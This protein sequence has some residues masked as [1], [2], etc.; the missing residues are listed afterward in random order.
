MSLISVTNM[1]VGDKLIS[2]E[3]HLYIIGTGTKTSFPSSRTIN[4]IPIQA[5]P[6]MNI[7]AF[8]SQFLR[9]SFIDLIIGGVSLEL[10]ALKSARSYKDCWQAQK[11][12]FE[13]KVNSRLL[14]ENEA[15]RTSWFFS[16]TWSHFTQHQ[17]SYKILQKQ[18][19]RLSDP[20]FG[21]PSVRGSSAK[22]PWI[23]SNPEFQFLPVKFFGPW[24]PW[25]FI[26]K[27]FLFEFFTG[28]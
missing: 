8:I 15:H 20:F 3:H 4:K 13:S 17:S 6:V 23:Y 25:I 5:F 12:H 28:E 1:N 22:I 10:Y 21:F 11:L 19:Y 24:I 18:T 9:T 26:I 14:N 7:F 16:W 27:W 2:Y